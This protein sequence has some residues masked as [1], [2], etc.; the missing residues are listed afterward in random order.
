MVTSTLCCH[1]YVQIWE[2]V[3]PHLT[4]FKGKFEQ[5]IIFLQMS[6]LM[7]HS[8]SKIKLYMISFHCKGLKMYISLEMHSALLEMNWTQSEKLF[9]SFF[10]LFIWM[11]CPQILLLSKATRIRGINFFF[12]FL[13]EGLPLCTDIKS[14]QTF[15]PKWV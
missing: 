15:T 7:P 8:L 1:K 5:N 14:N 11:C 12:N 2:T 13:I 6:M 3:L 9:K 4:R 10:T